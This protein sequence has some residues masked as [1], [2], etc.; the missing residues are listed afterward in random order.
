MGVGREKKQEEVHKWGGW[1]ERNRGRAYN[2]AKMLPCLHQRRL[3]LHRVELTDTYMRCGFTGI[4][5]VV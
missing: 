2:D 5:P 1:V 3:S 4:E